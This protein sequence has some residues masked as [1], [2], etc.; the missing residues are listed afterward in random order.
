MDVGAR[1]VPCRNSLATCGITSPSG[2]I[3]P[4]QRGLRDVLAN[5]LDNFCAVHG[6][7]WL[8]FWTVFDRVM[9]GV[10]RNGLHFKWEVLVFLG[11]LLLLDST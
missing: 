7:N 8:C 5:T 4:I 6:D 3:S 10:W 1:N 2:R 11:A 9:N